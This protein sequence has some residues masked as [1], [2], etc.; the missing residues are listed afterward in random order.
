[1]GGKGNGGAELYF[2]DLVRALHRAGLD[3]KIVI[4]RHRARAAMLREAGLE[5]VELP[6]G[7]ALDWR[8]GAKLRKVIADYRPTIVQSWMNRATQFC[9]AGDFVHVGWLA[10]Y[11][12]MANYRRCDRLVGVTPDIV[13]DK[14]RDGWPAERAHYIPT[15][16]GDT[17]VAPVPR[18]GLDTPQDAPL[19]LSLGRLHWMKALDVLLKAVAVV[20]DAW[21]WL[22][23]DGPLEDELKTLAGELGIGGRVR[24]LG[25]RDDREALLA[26][27]DICVL[28]S[29][30]E[31]FGTVTIE[32]W[33]QEK[34]M[35]VADAVGP[36][37]LVEPDVDAVLVPID[38]VAALAGAIRRV[39]DDREF[40]ARIAAAGRRVFEER[41]T[42]P[43]VVRQYLDFYKDIAP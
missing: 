22:A 38:D 20:P 1:M 32:A 31:S 35:I 41:F 28:P 2:T 15:F 11:Y 37:N 13:A 42:E 5:P 30:Y 39:I 23:G 18:A 16:A 43:A 27:C 4:R 36:K 7:G 12:K 14:V 10:G 25:W 17:R 8:T 21:L 9:P 6:F 24:F 29:R 26:A 40:A 19:L 33:S 3:Q 34:P